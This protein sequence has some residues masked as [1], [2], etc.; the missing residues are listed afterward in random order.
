MLNPNLI[1]A[2]FI[3]YLFSIPRLRGVWYKTL[4][5]H[6]DTV[7]ILVF[8]VCLGSTTGIV[9]LNRLSRHLAIIALYK[10]NN[11]I[12]SQTNFVLFTFLSAIINVYVVTQLV[13]GNSRSKAFN[14]G[15]QEK[16]ES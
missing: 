7:L 10:D 9:G 2:F 3:S 11:A 12:L 6:L 16:N 4:L 14:L 8:T 13:A 1:S 5:N 15:D